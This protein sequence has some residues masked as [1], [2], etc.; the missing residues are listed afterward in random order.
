[1]THVIYNKETTQILEAPARSVRCYVRSYKS[2][3]AAKAAL[4]RLD[5]KG[6]LGTFISIRNG[7]IPAL[8]RA[9]KEDFAICEAGEFQ[10]NIEKTHMVRSAMNG[11]MVKESVNTPFG[12]SVASE[13]YW[14]S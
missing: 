8:I 9:T 13:N 14:C 6:K 2:A 11:V 5:K 3:G 4:T 7:G 1:M 10:A 12:N